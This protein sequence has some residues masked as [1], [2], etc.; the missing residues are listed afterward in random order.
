MNSSRSVIKAH[1]VVFS[2]DDYEVIGQKGSTFRDLPP[3][4]LKSN[5]PPPS[6]DGP[7]GPQPDNEA[8]QATLLAVAQGQQI[9][10]QAREQAA[11][12]TIQARQ[13]GL[14]AAEAEAGQL[15]L[16]AK[17]VLD[18]V[19]T[20]RET[21]LAGS[22]QAALNLVAAIARIIFGESLA[23]DAGALKSAFARALA[24]AKPLGD[25]RIH[26]HPDD[27]DLLDPH[28]PQQQSAQIGQRLELVPDPAVRRGG[29]LVEGQ[30]GSVDARVETQMQVALDAVFAASPA[31]AP[32]D[33]PAVPLPRIAVGAEA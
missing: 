2:I 19:Q 25:L 4:E 33:A 13:E 32:G 11:E 15:L 31:V 9:L 23:L 24:E 10:R 6:A 18:E 29:C 28:W 3:V 27:T 21:M 26:V 1:Q 22:E 14:A 7:D 5:L 20:W 8:Q 17:G 16:S 12:T 30:Y